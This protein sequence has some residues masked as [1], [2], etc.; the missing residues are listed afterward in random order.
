MC[1]RRVDVSPKRALL[2]VVATVDRRLWPHSALVTV[3]CVMTAY[4]QLTH[5]TPIIFV[6]RELDVSL[7]AYSESRKALELSELLLTWMMQ[8]SEDLA[9][10]I[11]DLAPWAWSQGHA[12]TSTRV[13]NEIKRRVANDATLKVEV[14]AL[15]AH[16]LAVSLRI[17][18]MTMLSRC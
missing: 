12:T 8:I 7:I 13:T 11:K 16:Q 9:Q 10:L 6:S 17:C 18:I 4:R 1:L 14:E 3:N 5:S 15:P 2:V